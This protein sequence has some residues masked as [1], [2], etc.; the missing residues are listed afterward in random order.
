MTA[1]MTLSQSSP[2]STRTSPRSRPRSPASTRSASRGLLRRRPRRLR[3]AP[4]RGVRADRRARDPDDLRQLRLRDRARPR[5][6]RLRVH[7]SRRTVRWGSGRW[8]WTLAEHTGQQSKDFMR[9]YL[10]FDVHFP[11]GGTRSPSSPRL[12]AQGQ[13]IPFRGQ[14]GQSVPAPRRRRDRSRCWSFGHTHKP[15]CTPMAASCSSTAAPVGKPKDG[16]PRSAFGASCGPPPRASRSRSS[17]S[18]YDAEAV[19]LEVAAVGLPEPV[20]R[21]ALWIAA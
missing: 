16:D 19:A 2:T 3:P 17:A 7:H 4:E 6:L 10:P 8:A 13:R 21:Q 15:G 5:R 14:A 9:E 1:A 20:R 12:T 11:V 18:K